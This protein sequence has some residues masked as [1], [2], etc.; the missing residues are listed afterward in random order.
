MPGRCTF[1]TTSRPSRNAAACTWPS[2][3]R[4][5]GL[6]IE[7]RESLRDA[8]AELAPRRSARPPRRGRASRC[9]AGAPA[10][11]DTA[12]GRRS[13]RLESTCPSFTKVGP[14][15]SRSSASCSGSAFRRLPGGCLFRRRSRSSSM[16]ICLT[17]SERPYFQSEP[18]DVLVAREVIEVHFHWVA[19]SR[20]TTGGKWRAGLRV[21]AS[22]G[23][24]GKE[25]VPTALSL[26]RGAEAS[27]GRH[28]GSTPP[29]LHLRSE[30]GCRALPDP[31]GARPVLPFL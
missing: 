24:A 27:D 7:A 17:R 8:H 20:S 21:A 26:G 1:T 6:R 12:G 31:F 3:A 13:A 15:A 18:G 16:S 4:G 29:E 25:G 5:D 28:G 11:S 30:Q 9:P 10:P 2:E 22:S 23:P 19:S 14:I